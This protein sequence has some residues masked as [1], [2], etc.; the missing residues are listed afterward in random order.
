MFAWDIGYWWCC[1]NLR[2]QGVLR[3]TIIGL[4]DTLQVGIPTVLWDAFWLPYGGYN[5]EVKEAF[6]SIYR[7]EI[8]TIPLGEPPEDV[9]VMRA[10]DPL[11][12]LSWAAFLLTEQ[13]ACFDGCEQ[14]RVP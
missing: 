14:S 2:E 5:A 7:L 12:Y 6:V 3:G 11:Q 9:S 13:A 1:L 10:R 8:V 4:F